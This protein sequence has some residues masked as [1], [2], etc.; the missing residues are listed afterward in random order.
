MKIPANTAVEQEQ[1]EFELIPVGTYP[2]RVLNVK[3]RDNSWGVQLE[4]QT[5]EYAGKFIWDNLFFT[6]KA[7]N[8]F[9]LVFKRLTGIELDRTK[10]LEVD[11]D[12][13]IGCKVNVKVIHDTFEGKTRAKPHPW[14]GYSDYDE[15]KGKSAAEV[16][17]ADDLPNF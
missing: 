2:C 1:N 11:V 17:G 15:G 6:P 9:F 13:I 8:R 14:E 10:D 7:L 4:I 3:E 12:D 16:L 5:G